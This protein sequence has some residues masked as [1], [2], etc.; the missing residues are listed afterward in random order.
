MG[1]CSQTFVHGPPC[2]RGT[3]SVVVPNLAYT[4]ESFKINHT[5]VV[6]APNRPSEFLEG[7]APAGC[8]LKA[9]QIL[10]CSQG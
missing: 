7:E 4:D 8:Y 5:A 3:V 9:P 6:R 10:I 1:L 2:I